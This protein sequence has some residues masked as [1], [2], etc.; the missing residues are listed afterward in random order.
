MK[1]EEKIFNRYQ[2]DFK[3]LVQYGFKKKG[4]K[5]LFEKEIKESK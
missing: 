1:L 3:K 2:P 5:Y 4:D